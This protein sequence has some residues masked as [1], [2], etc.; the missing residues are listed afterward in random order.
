M[1]G[2]GVK[3]TR[4]WSR[5]GCT[6]Q[7]MAVGVIDVWPHPL[8]VREHGVLHRDEVVGIAREGPLPQDNV[9]RSFGELVQDGVEVVVQVMSIGGGG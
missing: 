5:P 4:S 2:A 6:A 1:A 7:W 9:D 3:S 8:L